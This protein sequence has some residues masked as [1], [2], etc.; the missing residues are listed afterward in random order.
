MSDAR[1][2]VCL[3]HTNCDVH[4]H[5]NC[6]AYPHTNCYAYPKH[7]NTRAFSWSDVHAGLSTSR[8]FVDTLGAKGPT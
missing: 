5:T 1:M 4:S 8:R 3:T 7:A 6:Y 2:F